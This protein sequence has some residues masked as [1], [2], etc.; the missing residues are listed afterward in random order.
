V[1]AEP[2]RKL[3]KPPTDSLARF[4]FDTI[5]HSP[6]VLAFLVGHVGAGRVLLGSDYPFDMGMPEG[7]QQIRGSSMAVA[8]QSI[9]LGGLARRLLR[10]ADDTAAARALA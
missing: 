5:V 8:D 3:P 2:K 9:I 4:Y 6:E 7:V 1:R 10:A